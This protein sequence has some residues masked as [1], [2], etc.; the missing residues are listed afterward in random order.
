MQENM[1]QNFKDQTKEDC[2]DT[3]KMLCLWKRW[4]QISSV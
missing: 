3:R 2:A 4:T 1:R